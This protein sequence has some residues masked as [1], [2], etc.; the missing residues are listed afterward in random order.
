M[1]SDAD[2]KKM[3]S[4]GKK[5]ITEIEVVFFRLF[6]ILVGRTKA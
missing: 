1:I 2:I 6:L 3:E 5:V 4:L